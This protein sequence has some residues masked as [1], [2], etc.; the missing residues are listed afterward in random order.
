LTTLIVLGDVGAAHRVPVGRAVADEDPGLA[1]H[2]NPEAVP[3]IG[4]ERE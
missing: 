1:L 4:D 3:V 2:G